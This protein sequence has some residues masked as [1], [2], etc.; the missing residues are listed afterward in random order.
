MG[1]RAS[2][3]PPVLMHLQ[4]QVEDFSSNIHNCSSVPEEPAAL[5]PPLLPIFSQFWWFRRRAA[6]REPQP[7]SWNSRHLSN[8]RRD[9]PLRQNCAYRW[10]IHW[11]NWRRGLLEQKWS[12]FSELNSRQDRW[13]KCVR[14]L[15]SKCRQIL[16]EERVQLRKFLQVFR[17]ASLLSNFWTLNKVWFTLFEHFDVL[18]LCDWQCAVSG[19]ELSIAKCIVHC[20]V[21]VLN[22]EVAISLRTIPLDS[23]RS[24]LSV[25]QRVL[26][27]EEKIELWDYLLM[28]VPGDW[29][30]DNHC[31]LPFIFL[32]V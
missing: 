31:E 29:V 21:S 19:K 25:E 24:V 22:D 26:S 28:L 4:V 6:P 20:L 9:A 12:R 17:K 18:F 3:N 2:T 32:Q 11:G 7:A 15:F 30:L 16:P 23:R 8:N 10:F 1:L 5:P 27:R 13:P 14:G